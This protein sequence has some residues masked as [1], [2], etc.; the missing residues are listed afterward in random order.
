[1]RR[2]LSIVQRCGIMRAG[3]FPTEWFMRLPLDRCSFVKLLAASGLTTLTFMRGCSRKPAMESL[4]IISRVEWGAVDINLLTSVE[5][6]Y[7]PII[8]PEG[9]YIYQEPLEQVL[10]T[11]VVH[12]SAR[13]LSDGPLEIQRLHME[14]KG[15]AD[16]GYHYMIDETGQIYEGRLLTVRGAHTGGHNTGTVGI[17][18]MG[19][20]EEIEPT[21]AQIESLK[22][23]GRCLVKDYK[24]THLAGHRDFQPGVTV[25]P[26]ENLAILLPDI[27]AGL[28]LEFGTGGYVGPATPVA[29]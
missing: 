26:G 10:N 6:D 12:H 3:K 14:Q 28:E 24:I 15:Y 1:M 18:L 7:D 17:A 27:A 2:S 19:N 5:G 13:P 23:L 29:N 8:N 20:F 16:I 4:P 9:W 11:I 22:E 21:E 25:C